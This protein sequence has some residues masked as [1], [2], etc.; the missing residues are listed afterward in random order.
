VALEETCIYPEAR[1]R[2]H[3]TERREMG[4]EMAA[5]RR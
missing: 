2:T 4:R 3:A 5:R 1:A